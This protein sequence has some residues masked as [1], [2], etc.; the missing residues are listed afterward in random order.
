MK[1]GSLFAKSTANFVHTKLGNLPITIL[2]SLN[3]VVAALRKFMRILHDNKGDRY[4]N[5]I[6]IGLAY[7]EKYAIDIEMCISAEWFQKD[8]IK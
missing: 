7:A 6:N 5:V 1:S 8:E 3:G 4:E 2:L